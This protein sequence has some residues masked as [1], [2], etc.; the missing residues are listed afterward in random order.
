MNE[1]SDRYHRINIG[2]VIDALDL[3]AEQ[4]QKLTPVPVKIGEEVR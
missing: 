3:K 4:L 2:I 1:L